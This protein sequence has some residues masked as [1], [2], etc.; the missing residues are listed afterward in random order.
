M[1]FRET[2]QYM[3]KQGMHEKRLSQENADVYRLDL[4]RAANDA[5][6][7]MY[8]LMQKKNLL[9]Y[10]PNILINKK[11]DNAYIY[12]RMMYYIKNTNQQIESISDAIFKI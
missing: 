9:I 1:K 6:I 7:N 10:T 8:Q 4:V 3:I 12:C 2:A 5:H 11:C